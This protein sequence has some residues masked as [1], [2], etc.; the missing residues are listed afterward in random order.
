MDIVAIKEAVNT[1]LSDYTAG[2]K[3]NYLKYLFSS[4]SEVL[5]YDPLT[6]SIVA[7]GRCTLGCDMCP[8]HSRIVPKDYK[9]IQKNAKDIDFTLFTDIIGRFKNALTLQIIGSGEPL[10]NKDLFRMIDYAAGRSMVVK[11]FSN[12]TTIS[13]NIGKILASRLEGITISLNGH[14]PEEFKRMTGMREDIYKNI[15][16]SVKKLIEERN[17][18][19]SRIRVKLSHIIDKYNYKF[20]P[21]MIKTSLDLGA[22]HVFLCN[23]LAAPY[24]GLNAAERVL[25]NSSEVIRQI[26]DMAGK[27]PYSARRKITFPSLLDKNAGEFACRSHFSQIRFDGDGN[28]SS[29]S[30]M[31]LNMENQGKY[32]DKD[33]WNNDFFKEARRRFLS[34]DRA[35]LPKPCLWCPDNFGVYPWK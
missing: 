34:G 31:L 20:I 35:V 32:K 10:L 4:G 25:E 28:V 24:D 17:R 26:N 23:F 1:M 6:I 2:Q 14:N 27:M 19:G 5:E 18:T 21:Q 3:V 7:T 12:G 13:D 16:N 30:M 11:T 8:T 29:C 33:V 9:Y 15:Y 22:D